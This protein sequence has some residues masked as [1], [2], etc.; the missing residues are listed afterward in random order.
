MRYHFDGKAY[1]VRI[2]N[3]NGEPYCILPFVEGFYYIVM[4]Y[5]EDHKLR[6]RV[7][8]SNGYINGKWKGEI[9]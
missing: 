8:N 2:G 1:T 7:H 9:K 6:V 4:G 3:I 5:T